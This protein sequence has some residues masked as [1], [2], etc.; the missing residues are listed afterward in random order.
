MQ[1]L[2]PRLAAAKLLHEILEKGAGLEDAFEAACRQGL[3]ESEPP[4]ERALARAILTT[5]LRRKG[6]IDEILRKYLTRKPDGLASEIMAV[7]AAQ[8][9]FMRVPTHAAISLANECAR[10]DAPTAHLTGLINAVLRKA[11]ADEGRIKSLETKPGIDAPRWL[12]ARW[13]RNFGSAVAREIA[14]AHL[15]EPALDISVKADP[16]S[17]AERLGASLLP[18][19]SLRLAQHEGRIDELPGFA[20][21]AW[22]VQDQAA[23]L[24]VLLLGDVRG[25]RVLDLCAAPGGKS[26]QL[27]SRGAHVTSLDDSA[28][29]MERL[30][31]NLARLNLPAETVVADARSFTPDEPFDAVLL[32][33]PCSATGTLRR[34]PDIAWHRSEAQIRELAHLQ[35]EMLGNAARLVKPG[36]VL[37]FSTCSLEPEEGELHLQDVPAGLALDPIGS[38]ELFDARLLKSPGHLRSLPQWGLDGFFAARFRRV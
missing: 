7:A 26:A 33:A 10:K 6:L 17:W 36:G 12:Y 34:H 22:W 30:K 9:L 37:V 11:V 1:G 23:C 20:E 15:T 21:G 19:G 8:I 31:A 3:L 14:A 2:A 25:K 18:N 13:Q 5:A 24:P 28:K 4:R 32:D 16:Q 27:A 38:G 29:R 35:R